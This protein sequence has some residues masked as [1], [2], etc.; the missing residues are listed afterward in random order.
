MDD[1][2]GAVVVTNERDVQLASRVATRFFLKP[3]LVSKPEDGEAPKFKD[4]E[5]VEMFIPGDKNNIVVK[6]V[7]KRIKSLYRERYEAWKAGRQELIEGTPVEHL[8]GI[9]P[10]QVE[11]LKYQKVRTVEELASLSDEILQRLGVG[12][13]AVS[14]NA[15]KYLE[16]AASGAQDEKLRSEV[17]KK[18]AEIAALTRRLEAL[19]GKET[20]APKQ[21][22]AAS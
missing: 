21:S 1:W 2:S 14:A 11:E 16:R 10:S 15:Q 3:R 19:E 18:D 4:V 6:P 17:S 12:Y 8:P 9:M 20:K 7:D 13:R 22:K 5:F